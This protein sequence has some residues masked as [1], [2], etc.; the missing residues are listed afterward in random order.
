MKE[1]I[2]R[3][4]IEDIHK[5]P[6]FERHIC[7]SGYRMSDCFVVAPISVWSEHIEILVDIRRNIFKVALEEFVKE[8]EDI[9]RFGYFVCAKD[10]RPYLRFT[11]KKEN[12]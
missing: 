2:A 4:L 10:C 9:L 1:E 3:Q 6:V 7:K 11:V 5:V 12:K 8:H